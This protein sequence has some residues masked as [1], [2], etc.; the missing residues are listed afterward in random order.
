MRSEGAS[1][2]AAVGGV[3]LVSPHGRSLLSP[4]SVEETISECLWNHRVPVSCVHL[5]VQGEG[6]GDARPVSATARV[7]SV[8]PPGVIVAYVN[9]NINIIPYVTPR[10]EVEE[11]PGFVTEWVA[12]GSA[13]GRSVAQLTSADVLRLGGESVDAAL[14]ELELAPDARIVV[15]VSGGG[16]SNLLLHCLVR[17]ARLAGREILPVMMLGISDWDAQINAARSICEDLGLRLAVVEA[18]EAAVLAGIDSVDDAL[19]R[20]RRHFGDTGHEFFGT[21]LL[22]RVLSA[23]AR[24]AGSST[25]MF[26]G[27]REDALAEALFLVSSG[28]LPLPLPVRQVGDITIVDPLYLLPKKVIDGAFPR[29]SISN[30]LHREK[31]FDRGR[32]MFY[33]L[34]NLLQDALPGMDLSLLQGLKGIASDRELLWDDELGDFTLG[35]APAD[36]KAR[37]KQV[38]GLGLA[39]EG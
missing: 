29:F 21:W 18:E 25:V 39:A 15:G 10:V 5:E 26:G 20:F 9:R 28:R 4:G 12:P 27:N 24:R 2:G 16:D 14:A 7:A 32:T 11:R 13:H 30:Y 34:V 37:W 8:S 17:S 35:P 23:Y 1:D 33:Y 36:L 22:R 31:S 38:I 3:L 19:A 6:A